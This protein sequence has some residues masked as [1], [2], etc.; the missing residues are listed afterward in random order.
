MTHIILNRYCKQ[1]NFSCF[2]K[3]YQSTSLRQISLRF[4][5]HFCWTYLKM[6]TYLSKNHQQKFIIII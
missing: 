1:D 4:F 3:F 6:D 5:S 2:H